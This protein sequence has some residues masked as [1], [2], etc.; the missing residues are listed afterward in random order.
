MQPLRQATRLPSFLRL[1]A[2]DQ[3]NMTENSAIDKF[4]L[5]REPIDVENVL[6]FV[7]ADRDRRHRHV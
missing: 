1:V 5:I 3:E 6:L 7:R 4:T 2:D